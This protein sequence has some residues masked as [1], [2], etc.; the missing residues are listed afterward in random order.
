MNINLPFAVTEA[1]RAEAYA[2][3]VPLEQH[4]QQ[5]LV[6]YVQEK[7]ARLARKKEGYHAPDPVAVE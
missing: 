5:I 6:D 2:K 1:L 4:V 3:N 7:P